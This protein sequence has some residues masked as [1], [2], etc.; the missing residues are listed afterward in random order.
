M[1]DIDLSTQNLRINNEYSGAVC[2]AQWIDMSQLLYSLYAGACYPFAIPTSIWLL[3]VETGE[4]IEIAAG[5]S[6]TFYLIP[7]SPIEPQ[8]TKLVP[9]ASELKG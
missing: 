6:W 7:A 1:I 2:A 8:I 5:Q 3:N 4:S 9:A